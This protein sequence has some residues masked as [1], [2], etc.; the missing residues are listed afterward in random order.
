MTPFKDN[1]KRRGNA[2]FNVTQPADGSHCCGIPISPE[3]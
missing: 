2:R 1:K 3:F